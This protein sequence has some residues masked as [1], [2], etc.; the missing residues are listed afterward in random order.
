[1]SR[2]GIFAAPS[3][4]FRQ[5][6]EGPRLC[7][8]APISPHP[9]QFY[10][11]IREYPEECEPY[12]GCG[13]QRYT[14]ATH[15]VLRTQINLQSADFLPPKARKRKTTQGKTVKTIQLLSLYCPGK[16]SMC[17]FEAV[18]SRVDNLGKGVAN[19]LTKGFNSTEVELNLDRYSVVLI[20]PDYSALLSSYLQS[21]LTQ[22][23]QK[24]LSHQ[25]H[26][27]K[28]TSPQKALSPSLL[29]PLPSLRP[30]TV[31]TSSLDRSYAR[32]TSCVARGNSVT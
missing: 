28:L 16:F 26:H 14:D 10:D 7:R 29:P 4:R 8:L 11:N 32:L 18:V 19:K 17:V 30:S 6:L 2:L 22:V 15:C 27:L 12:P 20:T 3:A 5:R 31:A 21:A 25:T 13:F 1:M 24:E 23:W 9:L